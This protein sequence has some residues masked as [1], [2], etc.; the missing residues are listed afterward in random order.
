MNK[1]DGKLK[2]NSQDHAN[3]NNQQIDNVSRQT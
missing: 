1:K 3:I 2:K